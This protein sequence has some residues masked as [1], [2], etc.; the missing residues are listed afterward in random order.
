MRNTLIAIALVLSADILLAFGA[1]PAKALQPNPQQVG[2][3]PV[4][5]WSSW[6]S[7]RGNASAAKDEAVARAMVSSGLAKLGYRYVNQDDGWY[8]C[9]GGF[10]PPGGKPSRRGAPTVNQWG[11]W[12]PNDHFPAQGSIN[13]IKALA[14]YLHGLGLKFGIYLTPGISAEAVAKNTPVEGSEA[15]RL[16]GK[17]SGYTA[18]QI[19]TRTPEQNYDCGGSESNAGGM[20]GLNFSSPGAQ[21]YIDS[22]ADTLASWGVDFIKL[23]GIRY[24]TD[25]PEIK[26]WSLALRQTGRPINFDA[27]EGYTVKLA[28]TLE[29]YA[30]QWEE[31]EDIECYSCD[32]GTDHDQTFP[33]TDAFPLTV[34]TDP[35]EKSTFGNAPSKVVSRFD[36]AAQWQPYAH[37]GGFNDLDSVEVGNGSDDGISLDAR[38]TVLS[39]WSLASSPLLLG[40]DPRY[41]APEDGVLLKNRAVLAVDQDGIAARR[42][43]GVRTEQVFAKREHQGDVVVGLFNTSTTQSKKIAIGTAEIGLPAGCA[44]YAIEDLWSHRASRASAQIAAIVPP[45][46]VA[47]LRVTPRC[48]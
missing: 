19:A 43:R 17:P 21:L 9:P 7:F 11:L 18:D 39:L 13:G 30:T 14:D 46:G 1:P 23:D 12:I 27:T 10:A 37:P 41:L 29:K 16:T 26:A 47:L 33:L 44:A 36:Y 15:G 32:K 28:P 2:I 42:I 22:W 48:Q 40:S 24:P 25:V 35:T 38:K 8:Q 45:E 34:W 3:K 31:G 4:L 6:S 20:V 5:G